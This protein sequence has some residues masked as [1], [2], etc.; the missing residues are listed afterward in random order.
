MAPAIP[1]TGDLPPRPQPNVR[2][3]YRLMVDAIQAGD[4]PAAQQAF[5]RMTRGLPSSAYDGSTALG[6]IGATLDQ[7]DLKSAQNI[8][9]GLETKAMNVLRQVRRATEDEKR[10]SIPPGSTFRIT[11]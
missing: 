7:G 3:E 11:A 10:D 6:K 4:I 1:P 2:N 9:D 8:L 5:K